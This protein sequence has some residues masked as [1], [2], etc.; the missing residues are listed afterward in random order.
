MPLF[1]RS[2]HTLPTLSPPPTNDVALSARR[3]ASALKLKD[4]GNE[5]FKA[6]TYTPAIAKYQEAIGLLT[7]ER[8]EVIPVT[9]FIFLLLLLLLLLLP[10]GW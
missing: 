3:V 10:S 5:L 2:S 7:D 4:A 1:P 6:K 8:G 9:G